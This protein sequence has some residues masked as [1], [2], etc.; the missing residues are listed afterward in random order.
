MKILVTPTSM[1]PPAKSEALDRLREFSNDIVFNT[2][3]K[4]L[5]EEQLIPL[6]EGCDGYIAGLDQVT[7]RVLQS[8]P[9]LKAIS[10]YGVGYD[11]VNIKAAAQLGITVTNTPGVNAQAVAELAMGLILCLARK[12]P[13]LDR[14]TKAGEWARSTGMELCGKTIGIIGLGAVGRRVAKCCSGFGM[15]M[16][17]YDPYIDTSYCDAMDIGVRSFDAIIKESD[18]ITLHLPLNDAT[19]HVINAETIKTMKD[20]VILVNTSRGAII[21]EDA[22]YQ[23]LVS[24]KLGALGVDAFEVEPP[25]NSPLLSLD[26]VVATPHTGAHTREAVVNMQNLSVQN[27]IDVLSEKECPYTI[28]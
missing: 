12:L 24:G 14:R 26:N 11:R 25:V 18:I 4:P 2:V 16:L 6:L 1:Q 28:R 5:T 8:C 10:R 19:C 27:L 9:K 20:G 13:A 7:E 21:D 17:A 3:G 15:D 23:A 22:A